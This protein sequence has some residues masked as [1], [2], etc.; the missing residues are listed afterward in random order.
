MNKVRK[1]LLFAVALLATAA[2]VFA[3]DAAPA[4]K[5]PKPNV[6]ASANVDLQKLINQFNA[7]RDTMLADREALMNQLKNAT[8]EQRKA[9]LEKVQAQEKDLLDQ[10]RAL[11][12]QIRDEMRK[13]RQTAPAGPGR[14]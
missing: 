1:S 3:A 6:P 7:R 13:L 12:R 14:R 10:Q 9:I 8:A 4:P 11:G 2:G 5:A